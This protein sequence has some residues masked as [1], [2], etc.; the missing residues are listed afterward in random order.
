LTFY[1]YPREHWVSIRTSN[2]IESVFA[3]VRL[4]TNAA[5]RIRSP[6]S[7]LYLIF[8]LFQRAQRN[9]RRLNAPHLVSKVIAGVKFEDGIEVSKERKQKTEKV[10]A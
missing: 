3:T 5:R 1:K 6:R 4:R 7:A 2:P 10:A 9:W 8:Q